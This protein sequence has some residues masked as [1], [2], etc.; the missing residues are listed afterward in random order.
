MKDK[1]ILITGKD[2]RVGAGIGG[3]DMEWVAKHTPTECAVTWQTHGSEPLS[4]H[5]MRERA[6]MA[7]ELLVEVYSKGDEGMCDC[8]DCRRERDYCDD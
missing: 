3:W 8:R 7:L 2:L 4:Q 6:L 5:K 1:D